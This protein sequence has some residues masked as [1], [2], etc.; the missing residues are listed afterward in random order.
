MKKH[1]GKLIGVLAA[2][3]IVVLVLFYYINNK[4]DSIFDKHGKSTEAE[5]LLEKNLE[6]YYPASQREVVRMFYRI[7]KCCY[8][9][10]ITEEQYEKL[11]DQLRILY[12]EEL[13][14]A[15]PRDKQR[16]SFYDELTLAKK[17][18]RIVSI[19]KV[20]QQ[21]AVKTWEKD[22]KSYSSIIGCSIMSEKGKK[23]TYVYNEYILRKDDKGRW[24]ILGWQLGD[25]VD[26]EE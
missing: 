20:Q 7:N 3:A 9:E 12:D 15:N 4:G 17:E 2:V 5:I 23:A 21:S 1:L 16:T 19:T 22:G 11:L 13:L 18:K 6:V 24:K 25:E 14:A 26:I 8:N 10:K